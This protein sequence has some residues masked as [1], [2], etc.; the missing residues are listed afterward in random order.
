MIMQ[1]VQDG[2]LSLGTRLSAIYPQLPNAERISVRMLLN[3]T[4]GLPDCLRNHVERG[5]G[6]GVRGR[7][8]GRKCA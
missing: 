8:R 4:S 1:E 6:A 7:G 3:M 5:L 2:H